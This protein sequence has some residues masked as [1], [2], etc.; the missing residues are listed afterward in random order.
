MSALPQH[1]KS[2]LIAQQWREMA[3]QTIGGEK[4][5]KSRKRSERELTDRR[6]RN[7]SGP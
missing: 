1:Q 2:E 3:E 5:K 6:R 4:A 7:S